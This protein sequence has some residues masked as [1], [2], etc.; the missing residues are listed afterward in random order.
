MN[1]PMQVLS[2]VRQH[3]L[4][5]ASD[6]GRQLGRIRE[7]VLTLT[8]IQAARALDHGTAPQVTAAYTSSYS[9]NVLQSHL[10]FHDTFSQASR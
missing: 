9:L 7:T 3:D 4:I 2:R 1:N 5:T 10:P 8:P 6:D